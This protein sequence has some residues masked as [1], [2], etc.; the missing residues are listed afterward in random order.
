MTYYSN[1]IFKNSGV[2]KELL[3]WYTTI[4]NVS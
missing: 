1:Q 4:V 3:S 2:E